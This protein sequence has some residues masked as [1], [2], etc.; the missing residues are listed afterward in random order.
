MPFFYDVLPSGTCLLTLTWGLCYFLRSQDLHTSGPAWIHKTVSKYL[1]VISTVVCLSPPASLPV[2][3]GMKFFIRRDSLRNFYGHDPPSS[4][5]L[6]R[7]HV[8]AVKA[9]AGTF[10]LGSEMQQLQ[11]SCSKYCS[12][13]AFDPPVELQLNQSRTQVILRS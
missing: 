6:W 8:P 13:L 7:T 3:G 1:S 2:S 12:T 5:K 11:Q 4:N 9:D 10:S